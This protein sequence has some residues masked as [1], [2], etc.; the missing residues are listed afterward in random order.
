MNQIVGTKENGAHFMALILEPGNIYLLQQGRP[1]TLRIEDSFPDG[2]PRRLELAVFYSETPIA[3]AKQLAGMSE[4]VLDE[5]TPVSKSKRPHCPECKST[6]EQMGMLKS[7]Q[8]PV[9]PIFCAACGC[10][11]G[12]VRA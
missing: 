10:V 7:D 12:I 9:H 8:A 4:V 6:V 1:I 3:D 11:L 2:V 5:R